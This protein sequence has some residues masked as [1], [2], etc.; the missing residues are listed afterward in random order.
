VI[1]IQT[2]ISRVLSRG[3]DMEADDI[4]L[5]SSVASSPSLPATMLPPPM[6]KRSA[7]IVYDRVILPDATSDGYSA[8]PARQ[9][10]GYDM[11][12]LSKPGYDGVDSHLD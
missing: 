12:R 2:H 8:L 1:A 5:P 7:S 3:H 10:T 11:V 6:S 9:T 4:S